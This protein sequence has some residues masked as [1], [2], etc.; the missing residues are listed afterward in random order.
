[1]FREEF[2]ALYCIEKNS[3]NMLA[4]QIGEKTMTSVTVPICTACEC[5]F[6]GKVGVCEWDY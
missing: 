4:F 3:I 2:F 5:C 1:M 6:R